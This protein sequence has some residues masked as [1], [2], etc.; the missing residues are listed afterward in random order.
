MADPTQYIVYMAGSVAYDMPVMDVD[1]YMNETMDGLLGAVKERRIK[2]SVV[3]PRKEKFF[4]QLYE[5]AGGELG[6][7]SVC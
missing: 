5:A 7:R 3:A 1:G 4:V 6:L 2:L